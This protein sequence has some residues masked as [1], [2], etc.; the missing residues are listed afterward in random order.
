MRGMCLTRRLTRVYPPTDPVAAEAR[1]RARTTARRTIERS[2][3]SSPGRLPRAF[4]ASGW[5]AAFLS[6]LIPAPESNAWHNHI[7][8]CCRQHVQQQ[9]VL[10]GWCCARPSAPDQYTS[11]RVLQE[12][13]PALLTLDRSC[14]SSPPPSPSRV[15][16]TES[17]GLA[18]PPLAHRSRTA[19]PLDQLCLLLLQ[20]QLRPYPC[21]HMFM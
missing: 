5:L 21:S 2:M 1:A 9:R 8:E 13:Q 4:R 10:S 3:Q 18:R 11:S 14:C 19:R 16:V 12:R 17:G 7:A 15:H 20:M 6:Q